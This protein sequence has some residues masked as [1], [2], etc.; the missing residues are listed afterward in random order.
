ML[1]VKSSASLRALGLCLLGVATVSVAVTFTV[2]T[3]DA[4][5]RHRHRHHAAVSSYSPAFSSIIVDANSGSTLQATSADSL[6]HPASLTK[7]MTLYMLFE[8]LESGKMKLDT[9]MDVSAHAS[10]Q[11]PTKLG[12]R[13][14]Q[15]IRV[16]DAIKGLVTR[17]ANDAAVVIAEAIAGDEDDFAKAMTRKARALGMSKTVY[18]NA[19]GLPDDTQVTTARDQATLGRAI[20]DRFP[21]YYRYFATEA[22]N[23]KGRSIRNHNKLLGRVEGV[24]GIKTGYTRASGFNLVTS[25]KRGNRY[26]VGVVMGG[27]SGGSRDA[28]MRN[29]LAENLDEASTRRTVAAITERGDTKVASAADDSDE[30]ET[31]VEAKA[32]SKSKPA[33]AVQVQG[34]IKVAS[35]P[36]EPV[37]LPAPRAPATPAKT[38]AE[39]Q[40]DKQD[41][42]APAPLT[43]GV[44][45]SQT[46]A[47]IPGSAEPMTPVRVKTVQVRMGQTKVA[48]AAPGAPAPVSTSAIPAPQKAEVAETS[49]AVVAKA[50]TK[51]ESRVEAKTEAKADRRAEPWPVAYNQPRGDFPAP[52]P[53]QPNTSNGIGQGIIGSAPASSSSAPPAQTMAYADPGRGTPPTTLGAQAVALQTST[54]PQQQPAPQPVQQAALP[55]AQP[56]QTM[57]HNGAIKT[58]ARSGWIIQVGALETESEARQRLDAARGSASRLL[59]DADPFTETVSKGNKTLYR[60]RFAGLNQDSAEAACRTLKRSDISCIAI[61]N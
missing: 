24:D 27:R 9:T 40:G 34:A 14:G 56:T 43:S 12:L 10:Q 18:K 49:K 25:M 1:G 37:P 2:D 21:K 3:A 7:I 33:A 36:P 31:K 45:S 53:A 46:F 22:F 42:P 59:S 28:I 29:L 20:Q 60:A 16:E 39:A 44:I 50:E 15:T 52:L 41:K 6:R 35:T 4:R 38:V 61:R 19:S 11:A 17:S 30:A 51:V 26:L 47:A 23:Y 48:S 54:A 55:P 58:V 13:P 32:E 57:Q 5:R 8:R